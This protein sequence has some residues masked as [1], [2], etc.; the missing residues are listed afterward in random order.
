M[1]V[2]A[3]TNRRASERHQVDD[4]FIAVRPLFEPL[5]WVKDISKD[6]LA[7]EYGHFY[8]RPIRNSIE[9][10]LFS[11]VH[12]LHI[13]R[14]PCRVIYDISRLE[15]FATIRTR[16]CGIQFGE[17]SEPQAAKLEIFLEERLS[18]N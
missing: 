6:G 5:G 7:F 11:S 3:A 1:S 10:D 2:E 9:V 12:D 4:V 14:I 18:K 15:P 16:R 13:P 17:L 8:Q